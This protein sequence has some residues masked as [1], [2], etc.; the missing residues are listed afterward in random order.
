MPVNIFDQYVK[1]H[2]TKHDVPK[3]VKQKSSIPVYANL[4]ILKE[5]TSYI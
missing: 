3:F 5:Q 1:C 2:V 4:D